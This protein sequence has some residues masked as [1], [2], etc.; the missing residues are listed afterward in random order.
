MDPSRGDVGRHK[1]LNLAALHAAQG[2]FTLRLGAVAVQWHGT[3]ATLFELTCE[4][5]RTVFRAGEHDGPLVLVHDVGRDLRSLVARHA[6]EVVINVARC[7]FADHVVDDG[8]VRELADQGL[9]IWAH[10]R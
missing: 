6:P 1:N 2:A 8:V 7:L 9:D 10:R 5:V 3:D 4:A